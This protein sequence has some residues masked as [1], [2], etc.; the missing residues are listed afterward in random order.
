MGR[1][2]GNLHI[3]RARQDEP[4]GWSK[5]FSI[6]TEVNENGWRRKCRKVRTVVLGFN[7]A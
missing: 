3:W 7:N 2:N 6:G 1:M 5:T 4:I